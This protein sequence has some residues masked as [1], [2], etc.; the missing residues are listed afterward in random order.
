MAAPPRHARLRKEQTMPVIIRSNWPSI[1]SLFAFVLACQSAA[2]PATA[3]ATTEKRRPNIVLILCDDLGISNISYCGA[4]APFRTPQIDALAKQSLRFDRCFSAPICGPSRAQI[5]TGQYGFRSGVVD[6]ATA[7]R[8]NPV[9]DLVMPQVMRGAG[10]KTAGAGKWSQLE[11]LASK[12]DGDR[13]G[14]DEFML[15]TGFGTDDRYWAPR[16]NHNGTVRTW[17]DKTYGPDVLQQ[18]VVE[19]MAEHK[20]DPFF[21]YYAHPIP[22]APRTR[23][24][25]SKN[26][27]PD[28]WEM[29]ADQV[30]YLDKQVGLFVKELERL[31]LREN[32]LVLFTGDN[33]SVYNETVRN[34]GYGGTIRGRMLDGGK[35]SA[36]EG[37]CRVPMFVSWPAVI[38]EGRVSNDLIDFS[39]FLPTF[40]ELAGTALPS[41][42]SCDG[43]SFAPQVRGEKGTP[44]E[45]VYAGLNRSADPIRWVR[46]DQWRLTSSGVLTSV[47]NAPFGDI[48]VNDSEPKAKAARERLQRVLDSLK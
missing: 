8:L 25:D 18:F 44:R 31:G 40:C 14:F 16:F 24:P 4:D 41:G 26:P 39:D 20:S 10:Y 1:V 22:H 23:T 35:G 29:Y 45:W 5:M 30:A 33:G 13:W 3:Q 42:Y 37:A 6:N 11:Y 19:F 38:R 17:D 32:T 46:D 34:G 9:E 15:W 7:A 43:R 27:K 12:D 2:A 36:G 21:V 47:Q 48:H 28:K